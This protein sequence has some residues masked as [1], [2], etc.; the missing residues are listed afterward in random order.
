MVGC[1]YD[2]QHIVDVIGWYDAR[3][4]VVEVDVAPHIA[5]HTVMLL[6][7]L[8]N[9]MQR[10]VSEDKLFP[11]PCRGIAECIFHLRYGNISRRL[12]KHGFLLW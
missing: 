6:D 7:A 8:E 5:G 3:E 9:L 1:F 2:L 12:V 10:D 4:A 11:F